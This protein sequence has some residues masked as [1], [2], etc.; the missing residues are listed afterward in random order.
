M[1]DF[2]LDDGHINHAAIDLVIAGIDYFAEV[3]INGVAVFDC[4][5]SQAV[6]RKDIKPYLK[7]GGNRIEIL[8]LEQEDEWLVETAVCDLGEPEAV[9]H[10]SRIGIWATPYLEMIP[11]VRLQ[12]VATEQVWHHGG[13]CEF[14]VE[15]FYHCLKPG[16]VAAQVK[17]NGM[18]LN[19][20]LDVRDDHASVL[21]QVEAPRTYRLE[22]PDPADLYLLQVSLDG[23]QRE[24]HIGLNS[25]QCVVHF[26]L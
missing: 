13:G 26:P 5:G 10:D 3:R 24:F 2:M 21:F 14:L 22:Q 17:F 1:H 11:Q 19:V 8:F 16:L 4:D 23:Q 9:P 15:L 6:Y 12:Y 25:S 7:S 20:P 18:T